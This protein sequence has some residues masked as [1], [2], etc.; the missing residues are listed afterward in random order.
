MEKASDTKPPAGAEV[1]PSAQ[2]PASAPARRWRELWQV[3]A[4]GVSAALL[5]A[6]AVYAVK[7]APAPEFGGPLDGAEAL[8][9]E[10]KYE[11][12]IELLNGKVFPYV[13]KPELPALDQRRFFVL[14]ARG[15]ALGQRAKGLDYEKNHQNI[16]STYLEAERQ[17]AKLE[18]LDLYNLADSYAAMGKPDAAL[19][20]AEQLAD[21]DRPR[22]YE[23]YKK[24]IDR[25]LKGPKDGHQRALDLLGVLQGDPDLPR[26][27]RV[28]AM[29][30]QA[31]LLMAGGFA[32]EAISKLLKAMPRLAI[33]SDEGLGPLFVALGRAYLDT[34]NMDQAD[35]Q[36]A[37]AEKLLG[38]HDDLT[39]RAELLRARVEEAQGRYADA[40]ERYSGV[41]A[42]FADAPEGV[43]AMLG[44]A[45][46]EAALGETEDAI[47]AYESL[48]SRLLQDGGGAEVTPA[49][50]A[51]SLVSRFNERF[52][53][54]ELPSA[55]KFITL[56]E[57]LLGPENATDEVVLGMARLNRELAL[58]ALGL[59]GDAEAASILTALTKTNVDPAAATQAQ[60]AYGAA[61][62]YFRQHA[63]RVVVTDAA[64]YAESLWA[65]ADCFD[66]AGRREDA[67]A[68]FK[69]FSTSFPDDPREPEAIFRLAQS[70]QATGD[71][72]SAAKL[73]RML[74]EQAGRTG[75]AMAGPFADASYVPLAQTYLLDNDAANDKQAE[76]LLTDVV[77]GRLGGTG[78]RNFR[79]ALLELGNH[80]YQTGQYEAAVERLEEALARFST[81]DRADEVRYRLAESL[82]LS[83]AGID[84]ELS[85]ALPDSR[86]R[87]LTEARVDRL[88]RA[89]A[90]YESA[91]RELE[92][93]DARRRSAVES[94]YLRNAYF[95]EGDCAYELG[96]YER[97]IR[98][99]DAARDRYPTDP[100]SLVAMVQIVNAH[101]KQGDVRRAM[102]ANK[103]ALAF[104]KSLPDVVWDDPNLPMTRK[105]WERWLQATARL[106]EADGQTDESSDGKASQKRADAGAAGN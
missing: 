31:E 86:R 105:D 66:R 22:R 73:Y 39:A 54:G 80:Y 7:H 93:K 41:L 98:A 75:N 102:T 8:I 103:R 104:Y 40:K 61:G 42:N 43:P 74:I 90:A 15:L 100:S 88:R 101:L 51:K 55:L 65:S 106:G 71:L 69:E 72:E 78:G 10:Q 64:R 32:E 12:A 2:A 17:G 23:V 84:K 85:A 60:R 36:L 11:E 9:G 5:I 4:L 45:E 94:L 48:V 1:A 67:I 52:D 57:T 3:P 63:D 83:A 76:S 33:P 82:R 18:G 27:D 50:V 30:R 29:H 47:A 38:E 58:D 79:E 35:E 14:L 91:R 37:R 6:G 62:R 81:D 34:G 20:R 89:G 21:A 99:Y 28:W 25:A 97:A 44:L 49:M 96:D 19:E 59:R 70:Y 92:N 16:V 87:D 77:S 26:T 68:A 13:G 56:A 53:A 24:V 95:Y 46:S